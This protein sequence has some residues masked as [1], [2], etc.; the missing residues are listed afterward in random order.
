MSADPPSKIVSGA[1]DVMLNETVKQSQGFGFGPGV[2]VGVSPVDEAFS[3]THSWKYKLLESTSGVF[4]PGFAVDPGQPRYIANF[5]NRRREVVMQRIQFPLDSIGLISATLFLSVSFTLALDPNAGIEKRYSS[6][7][8]GRIITPSSSDR[9][10]P[11]KTLQTTNQN[12]RH[13]F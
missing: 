12:S 1:V 2:G 7:S 8:T 9:E 6:P 13:F 5:L 4:R 10:T 11:A 3:Y